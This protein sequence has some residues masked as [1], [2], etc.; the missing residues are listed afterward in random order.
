MSTIKHCAVNH[1][2][3]AQQ[4]YCCRSVSGDPSRGGRGVDDQLT[5]AVAVSCGAVCKQPSPRHPRS[6]SVYCRAAVLAAA[7]FSTTPCSSH[8]QHYRSPISLHVI[9][10]HHSLT[11]VSHLT[12]CHP[13]PSQPH[14]AMAVCFG[15][16]D[17]SH[18]WSQPVSM[19]SISFRSAVA[20]VQLPPPRCFAPVS[21]KVLL[22]V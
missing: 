12:P 4:S 20:V 21:I 1:A 11:Q 10:R 5:G 9:A 19:S 3:N 14:T 2:G 6:P 7:G 8:A 17:C 15:T 16:A 22:A 18:A 13:T